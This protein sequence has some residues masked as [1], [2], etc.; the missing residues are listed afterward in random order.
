[1]E[2]IASSS[3]SE[4]GSAARG[5][6]PFPM[7]F[8]CF[9]FAARTS[10]HLRNCTSVMTENLYSLEI[11]WRLMD[12]MKDLKVVGSYSEPFLRRTAKRNPDM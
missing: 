9:C 11:R 1:M 6:F 8:N 12:Y 3:S 10:L 5:L 4:M 7:D 2:Y